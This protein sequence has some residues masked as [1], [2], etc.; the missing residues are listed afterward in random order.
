MIIYL[1]IGV[2]LFGSC[3]H[4]IMMTPKV[5]P[6]T[7]QGARMWN[8]DRLRKR[9]SFIVVFVVIVLGVEIG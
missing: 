1:N 7:E 8:R 4:V 2:V 3:S 9:V 5:D 6:R